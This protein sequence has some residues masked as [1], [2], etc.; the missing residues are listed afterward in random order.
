MILMVKKLMMR[1]TQAITINIRGFGSTS[2]LGRPTW[3]YHPA[4]LRVAMGLVSP[5]PS[6]HPLKFLIS[7]MGLAKARQAG[8]PSKMD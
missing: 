7:I 1:F 6:R 2:S 8:H 4:D 3:K 5:L